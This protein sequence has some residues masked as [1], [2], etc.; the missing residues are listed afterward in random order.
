MPMGRLYIPSEP[1]QLTAVANT[2]QQKVGRH[3]LP[4]VSDPTR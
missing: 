4:K 2:G 3:W 1:Q